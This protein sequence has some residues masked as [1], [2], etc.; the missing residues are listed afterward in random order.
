VPRRVDGSRLLMRRSLFA[1]HYSLGSA[2]ATRVKPRRA[3]ARR[4]WKTCVCAPRMSL[5]FSEPRPCT[6]SG[7]RKSAVA[8]NRIGRAKRHRT[9]AT[10]RM[11]PPRVAPRAAGVSQPWGTIQSCGGERNHSTKTDRHCRCGFRCH[12]GLTVRRSCKG[13]FAYC[14]SRSFVGKCPHRRTTKSGGRK[15]PV[16]SLPRLHRSSSS[17]R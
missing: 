17:H 4:S 6:R 16:D 12:G 14:T 5:F 9:F 8:V 3:H 2:S 11:R 10:I 13:A 7:W 1:E 15:P